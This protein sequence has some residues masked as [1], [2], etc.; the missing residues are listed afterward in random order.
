MKIKINPNK[1][2]V[3]EIT[4]AINKNGGFCCCAIEKTPDTK[5]I[6][7]VFLE[8]QELGECHC[9]KYIKVEL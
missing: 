2:L 5:C 4:K 3:E 7:R 1:E 8:Q 9:G 6:C